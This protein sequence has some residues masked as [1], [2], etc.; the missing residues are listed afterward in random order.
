[1]SVIDYYE[2]PI[3]GG[4]TVDTFYDGFVVNTYINGNNRYSEV[5]IGTISGLCHCFSAIRSG[6]N[7]PV[8]LCIGEDNTSRVFT[9]NVIYG[10]D[11]SIFNKGT[12]NARNFGTE[13]FSVNGK[14]FYI[15]YP[16]PVQIQRGIGDYWYI[17]G[18][19]TLTNG[20]IA[21]DYY[22]FLYGIHEIPITYVPV[23]SILNGP[24]QANIG[25]AV[26]VDVSFPDGYKLKDATQGSG[27]SVYNDNGYINFTYDEATRK[28]N[29]I[30][31]Q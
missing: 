5:Q 8:I 29:F 19:T 10:A 20:E 21:E 25:D 30:M 7:A 22:D 4:S 13:G 1:M 11:G 16:S 18:D 28:L 14:T 2:I 24:A 9:G 17:E 6:Y 12:P 27:I 15:T 31:P 26:E 23:S 3:V